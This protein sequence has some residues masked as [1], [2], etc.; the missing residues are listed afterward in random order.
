MLMKRKLLFIALVVSCISLGSFAGVLDEFAPPI[1]GDCD[2]GTYALPSYSAGSA[3]ECAQACLSTSGCTGFKYEQRNMVAI[4]SC[5]LRTGQGCRVMPAAATFYRKFQTDL[6]VKTTTGEIQ[7]FKGLTDGDCIDND[8]K[9]IN[10]TTVDQCGTLCTATAGDCVAF[11]FRAGDGRCVFKSPMSRCIFQANG[12]NY[13]S[14]YGDPSSGGGGSSAGPA[15]AP[16]DLNC[17]QQLRYQPDGTPIPG[18]AFP[19]ADQNSML[20]YPRV[21][22]G[23]NTAPPTDVSDAILGQTS[24]LARVMLQANDVF[25]PS[26][27]SSRTSGETFLSSLIPIKYNSKALTEAALRR[28]ILG[29]ESFS[30]GQSSVNTMVRDWV[31]YHMDNYC[32]PLAAKAGIHKCYNRAISPTDIQNAKIAGVTPWEN[33]VDNNIPKPFAADITATTLFQPKVL[34]SEAA[35]RYIYNLINNSPTPIDSKQTDYIV[36]DKYINKDLN[37]LKDDGY[38]VYM[39]Y[40]ESQSKSSLL[41]YA[42]MQIFA[43]RLELDNIKVPVTRW[44]ASGKKTVTYEKTSRQGLLE[45]EAT[46]RFSD[47][48]WYDRVQQMPTPA[49]LKELAYMQ[50]LQLT[51]EYKRYEQQQIQTAIMAS[52]ASDMST[53]IQTVQ[54]AASGGGAM[55]RQDLID[56][57]KSITGGGL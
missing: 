41:Q 6:P 27:L 20:I 26:H 25:P 21:N 51:L 19:Q 3:E 33:I 38:N 13:Y 47:P 55:S 5:T 23:G 36:P 53:L 18:G 14:K 12:Y 1:N 2:D 15:C 34:N 22:R 32:D 30:T 16:D 52:F 39:K 17:Q 43:E 44:D 7:T 31:E 29:A 40:L 8:I 57:I 10:V 45:F 11:S 28:S 56:Q 49:L 42:M 4:L 9:V 54:N 50:S 35:M 48:G 37:V 46:K 24:Y